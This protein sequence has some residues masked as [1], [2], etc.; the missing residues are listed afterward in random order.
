MPATVERVVSPSFSG[1]EVILIRHGQ[2]AWN[3]ERRFLGRT[4]V[5]LDATGE[6]QAQRLGARL[7]GTVDAVYASPLG[8]ALGTARSIAEPV[9]VPGLA[10]MDMGEL[11]G[12]SGPDALARFPQVLA[13]WREDPSR[14]VLPGGETLEQVQTRAVTAFHSIVAAHPTGRIAIVTHQLALASLLC[15]VVGRPLADFNTF[16]HRNC[17]FS[18]LTWPGRALL[19]RD[20]AGHLEGLGVT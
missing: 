2:T 20:E 17:A 6:A 11:E 13:A 12:L 8:R 16:T 14:V 19:L 4:D 5:P 10:E 9:L 7:R 1:L 15:G 3:T 18:V